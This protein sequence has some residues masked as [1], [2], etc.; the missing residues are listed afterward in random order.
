[1]VGKTAAMV[2]VC[3]LVWMAGTSAFGEGERPQQARAEA[4]IEWHLPHQF[5]EAREASKTKN[6]ILLIKGVS[7]G[8]DEAGA[9]C[10][11]KGKW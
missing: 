6:R 3:A 7:F 8:I 4:A 5:G 10:A 11:T 1:M 9:Q 2:G